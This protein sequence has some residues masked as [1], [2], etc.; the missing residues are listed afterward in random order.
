MQ[1]GGAASGID[2]ADTISAL[3]K[4]NSQQQMD[5]LKNFG[6][7]LSQTIAASQK[8]FISTILDKQKNASPQVQVIGDSQQMDVLK[9]FGQTLSQSIAAS[10]IQI[11]RGVL[12]PTIQYP[13]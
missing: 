13:S 7:T 3:L 2:I 9:G 4:E 10:Q 1:A 11:S 8:E 12:L 6:Q 5:V